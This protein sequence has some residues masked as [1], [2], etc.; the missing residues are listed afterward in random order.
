MMFLLY[1]PR[2]TRNAREKGK[3]DPQRPAMHGCTEESHKT[4]RTILSPKENCLSL[5][6]IGNERFH[7]SGDWVESG[8]RTL[9]H[10]R[11][12]VPVPPSLG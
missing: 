9:Y 6:D 1:N 5:E 12:N 8:K 4:L 2:Q 7:A 11:R 10:P 3:H